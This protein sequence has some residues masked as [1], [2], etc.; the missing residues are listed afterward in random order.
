MKSTSY[1]LAQVFRRN[2]L[3]GYLLSALALL[4]SGAFGLYELRSLA[5]F[6]GHIDDRSGSAVQEVLAAFAPALSLLIAAGLLLLVVATVSFSFRCRSTPVKASRMALVGLAAAVHIFGSQE[7]LQIAIG[8]GHAIGLHGLF[9]HGGWVLVPLV[10]VVMTTGVA[11]A[12]ALRSLE[13]DRPLPGLPRVIRPDGAS[14][15]LLDRR[16]VEPGDFI[17]PCRFGRGP[18]LVV[19]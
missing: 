19:S 7:L 16:V 17:S 10:V 9:A 8:D 14:I 6:Q 1:K 15:D 4:T 2:P 18:P 11:L 3:A 5:T 12:R 13:E